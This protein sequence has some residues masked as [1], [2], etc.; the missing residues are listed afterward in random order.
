MRYTGCT[1]IFVSEKLRQKGRKTEN[2]QLVTLANGRSC[3]CPEVII[4]IDTDYIPVEVK[5]L[6][7]N[8]TFSALVVGNV[9]YI[10]SFKSE[11]TF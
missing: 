1:T 4:S 10:Q 2:S 3:T 6:V 11:N 5:A 9:G 8:N 7:M